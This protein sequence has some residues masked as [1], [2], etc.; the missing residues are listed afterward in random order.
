MSTDLDQA[1]SG[2]ELTCVAA[3]AAAVALQQQHEIK[4]TS[5]RPDQTFAQAF[6]DSRLA[7]ADCTEVEK[8]PL[9]RQLV[10]LAAKFFPPRIPMEWPTAAAAAAAASAVKREYNRDA[11]SVEIFPGKLC[12]LDLNS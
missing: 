5:A 1:N 11:S 7:Y 10:S 4:P 12:R 6:L 8:L 2:N 9:P 3:L